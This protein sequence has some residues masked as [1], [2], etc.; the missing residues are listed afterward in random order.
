MCSVAKADAPGDWGFLYQRFS[1]PLGDEAC[2]FRNHKAERWLSGNHGSIWDSW[3]IAFSG[4]PR[5]PRVGC[6]TGCPRHRVHTLLARRRM[7]RE[8][9]CGKSCTHH[10][11]PLNLRAAFRR[12]HLRSFMHAHLMVSM[13]A[14]ATLLPLTSLAAH[15]QARSASTV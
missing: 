15:R 10:L 8:L 13:F 9:G 12:E 7:K 1:S 2:Q 5:G 3:P 11:Q 6:E 4:Y 14:L